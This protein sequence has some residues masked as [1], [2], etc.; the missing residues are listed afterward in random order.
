MCY[1]LLLEMAIL[2]GKRVNIINSRQM[3]LL[4]YL[5]DKNGLNCKS[6]KPVGGSF[7]IQS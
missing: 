4:G 6:C 3:A 1:Q 2:S 7:M 5:P